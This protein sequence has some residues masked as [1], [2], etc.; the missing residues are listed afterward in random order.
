MKKTL[1]VIIALLMCFSLAVACGGSGNDTSPPAGGGA[2]APGGGG[3]T[4]PGGGAASPGGGAASPGGGAASPGGGAASPSGEVG[5][6]VEA[7]G[8]TGDIPSNSLFRNAV[9][10][11]SP[12]VV[13]PPAGAKLADEITLIMENFVPNSIDPFTIG[14]TNSCSYWEYGL[15]YDRLVYP[16]DKAGEYLPHLAASWTVSDDYKTFIFNLHDNVYFHNGEHLKASDVVFTFD[17]AMETLGGTAQANWT[18]VD[19]VTAL[20]DYTVQMTLKEPNV[21][22]IYYMSSAASGI[23]SEKAFKDDPENGYKIGSGAFRLTEFVPGDY[24][25]VERNDDYWGPAPYTRKITAR[26]IPE[27]GTRS[28]MLVNRDA[29][30][31][32]MASVEDMAIFEN[33]DDYILLDRVTNSTFGLAFNTTA[34]V[35][36]DINFRK[37]VISAVDREMITI[38]LYAGYGAPEYGA[39][40]WGLFTE[41]RNND[42]PPIPEDLEAAKQYLAASTYNGE[43][44]ELMCSTSHTRA[45]EA[46]QQCLGM[47]GI[48][49]VINAMEQPATVE[50][51]AWGNNQSQISWSTAMVTPLAM[52]IRATYMPGGR[53]NRMEYDNPQL[54]DILDRAM[55]EFDA[56]KREALYKEAQAVFAVDVPFAS[57]FRTIETAVALKGFGGYRYLMDSQYDFV[58]AYYVVD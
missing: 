1:A 41:F 11:Y 47:I 2:A 48:N 17:L 43:V 55:T 30:F 25:V 26:F 40:V 28:I 23:A 4:S 56:T 54:V 34:A 31:I 44:V 9:Q 27:V 18:Y 3:E 8:S 39:T 12:T 29:E 42:I 46:V 38:A 57:M 16:T 33:D 21:D 7:A 50:Y 35:T 49:T 15:V 52:S 13:P 20:D 14:G 45:M 36:N 37:A 6:G 24:W 32:K 58:Y 53:S 19:E 10:Q 5:G 22:F 51:C